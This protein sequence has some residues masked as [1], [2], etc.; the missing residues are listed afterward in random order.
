M[1]QVAILLVLMTISMI[2]MGI[3]IYLHEQKINALMAGK[4]TNKGK[5]E[6]Y[7]NLLKHYYPQADALY[8]DTIINL[9]GKQGLHVLVEAK[10]IEACANFNERKLYVL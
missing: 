4:N 3:Y 9:V 10:A 8:E 7:Y 1:Y 2:V 5:A 6:Q